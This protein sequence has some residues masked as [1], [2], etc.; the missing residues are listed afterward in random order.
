VDGELRQDS[1]TRNMVFNVYEVV[2]HLSKVM[3]L[4]PCDIIATGTPA[5]VGFA[6]K[7]KPKFL[8]NGSVVRMEIEGIGVLEN[9][10]AEEE[11]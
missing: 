7:P 10:V 4:E 11:S 6:I 5:G 3:T 9:R 8:K 2:H 1:T